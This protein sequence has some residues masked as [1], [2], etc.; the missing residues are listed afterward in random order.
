[1]EDHFAAAPLPAQGARC[2]QRR[3]GRQP[4]RTGRFSVV[5]LNQYLPPSEWRRP[6]RRDITPQVDQ[7]PAA[8][9]GMR[10]CAHR[11]AATALAVAPRSSTTPCGTVA[12]R[13]CNVTIDQLAGMV[14]DPA[15]KGL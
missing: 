12:T 14:T 8:G 13:S 2:R 3:S 1:M 15:S 4:Y 9:G 11:S 10:P 5:V 6:G 7:N